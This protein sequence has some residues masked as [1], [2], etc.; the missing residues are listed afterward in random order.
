MFS[1]QAQRSLRLIVFAS[2]LAVAAGA[3]AA[4]LRIKIPKRTKPTPVQKLN[5]DGVKAIEKNDYEKAK[6]LFYKAYLIDPND[7]FTLNNLGYIAELE[8]ELERAQRYYALAAE[9]HSDAQIERAS[10]TGLKGRPVEEVAGRT[11]D[12]QMHVNRINVQAMG[13]LLKDRAPEADIA[14]QRALKLDP[15]NPFTLNNLGWAKEKEGELELALRYY[16]QSAGTNSREPVVVTVTKKWRGKSIA[17]VAAENARKVRRAI[18]DGESVEAK[19]ARLNLRGVSAINRN[20]R[21]LARQ[22][23]EQAY[24]LDPDNAFTLN[25]MGYLAEV[26]GDRETANFFYDKSRAAQRSDAPVAAATRRE[27]EGMKIGNVAAANGQV[28]DQALQAQIEQR[29]R[30][31][32]PVVLRRRDNTPVIDPERPPEPEPQ[33]QNRPPQQSERIPVYSQPDADSPVQEVMPPLDQQPAG[34][35]PGGA[36]PQQEPQ[37]QQQP[38]DA[39]SPPQDVMPPLPEGQQP[40]NAGQQQP[41]P[42]EPK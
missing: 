21:R 40:P 39:N 1:M 24:K 25:N 23:F 38:P 32:G 28:V 4:D 15:D 17:E 6:R 16:S 12:E 19:V 11:A 20:E 10:T 26:D 30:E 14:L 8:G 2:M 3:H 9:Q 5:Q 41:P 35:G 22:Y 31:G 13:L 34:A 37:G 36:L 33:L 18:D 27:M 42:E 7:P 29:R